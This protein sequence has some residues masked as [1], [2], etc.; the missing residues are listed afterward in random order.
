LI[1]FWR[2]MLA[3]TLGHARSSVFRLNLLLLIISS[4][5]CGRSSGIVTG[6]HHL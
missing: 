4:K 1:S 2:K 3:D 5:A 6:R